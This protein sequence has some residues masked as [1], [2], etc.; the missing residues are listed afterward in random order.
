MPAVEQLRK[1]FGLSRV[2]LVGDR[3]LLVP[4]TEGERACGYCLLHRC[5]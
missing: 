4:A 2:V 1:R 5:R 3:G